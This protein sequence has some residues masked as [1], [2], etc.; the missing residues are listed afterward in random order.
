MNW[1]CYYKDKKPVEIG[2]YSISFQGLLLYIGS[3]NDINRRLNEH[4]KALEQGKHSNK[5][6]QNWINKNT[7][8]ANLGFKVIH[9]TLDDCKF[10]LFMAEMICILMYK[11]ACYS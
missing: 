8:T 4:R 9:K 10:R 5:T 7:V 1:T 6:L 3:T 11:P 2:V